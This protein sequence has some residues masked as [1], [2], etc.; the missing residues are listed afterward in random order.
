VVAAYDGAMAM[1][2][3]DD[4]NEVVIARTQTERRSVELEIDLADT[5]HAAEFLE[6]VAKLI[7]A[8][9]K[10]RIRVYT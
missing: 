4:A 5:E 3:L 9:A 8:R 2:E 6:A 1:S 10:I 7:R